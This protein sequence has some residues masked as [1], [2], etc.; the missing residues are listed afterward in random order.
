MFHFTETGIVQETVLEPKTWSFSELLETAYPLAGEP[1]V[2]RH[3]AM[4]KVAEIAAEHLEDLSETARLHLDF[5]TNFQPEKI[6]ERTY[7]YPVASSYRWELTVNA[8]GLFYKDVSG[9]YDSRLGSVSEQLFSDFWFY[10]PMQPIPDLKLREKIVGILQDAFSSPE[11]PAATAHFELFEYPLLTDSNLSWSEGD[12]KRTDYVSVCAHGL[13]IGYSTWRDVQ[14][15]MWFKS[16]ENFLFESPQPYSAIAPEIRTKIERFLGRKSTFGLSG[17]PEP[18]PP[19][20]PAPPTPREKMDLADSLLKADPVSEKGAETLISL[21]EYEDEE[22]YWRNFVFNYLFKL[23]GNRTVENF[24][25]ECLRGD[26]EIHFKKA[27][28]VLIMWGQYGDKSLT[29]R[30]L[31]KQLNWEDAT[32]HDPNFREAL[33]KTIK[34]IRQNL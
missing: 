12:Y 11:C 25:I 34:I 10:G 28:D 13:E 7:L 22:S 23:R 15:Y 26:D 29:N 27:V 5:W 16:F 32:A 6:S 2:K 3:A 20:A 30:D 24:V 21:L 1:L 19:P 8:Q 18:T 9:E 14:P 33:E 31:F 4:R 17:S